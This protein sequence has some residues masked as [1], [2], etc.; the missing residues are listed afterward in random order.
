MHKELKIMTPSLAGGTELLVLA[1]IKPGFVPSLDAVTYKTRVKLLLKALH[2]G[3]KGSHEYQLFRTVSD[4]V[5]RVGVIHTVRVAVLEPENKV[6]L[7]VNFDGAYESYV[8][9]IWQKASRLLD[10]IFCN[11]VQPGNGADYPCGWEHSF[12]H[13]ATWLR[14]VTVETPFF[15]APP[16]LT[17]QDQQGL[18]MA[19]R[20]ARAGADGLATTRIGI[21]SAERMA[22][23]LVTRS[24]DPSSG[25]LANPQDNQA[26]LMGGI[27]QGLQGL[28]G[29]YRLADLYPPHTPDGLVL[30][31]AAHELLP[32]FARLQTSDAGLVDMVSSRF[33]EQVAWLRK[34]HEQLPAARQPPA[35]PNTVAVPPGAQGGIVLPYQ[36]ANVGLKP[37]EVTH[38]CIV[39]VSLGSA[40]GASALLQAL[41]PVVHT[42][43]DPVAPDQA[44]VNVAFTAEGLRTCGLTETQLDWLPDEFRQGM[45]AR[46]GVLGDVR[47]NHPRRWT[48]PLR[49]WPQALDPAW[50]APPATPTAPA[51]RVAMDAVHAVVQVRLIASGPANQAATPPT[52]TIANMLRTLLDNATL[53]AA[54]VQP[55]SVLWMARQDDAGLP[56]DHFG[57]AD[58][59]SQPG[60]NKPTAD[61]VFSNQVQLGEAL[62]GHD[63]AADHA[64]D[65]A[66]TD[67]ANPAR[68]ALLLNGSFLVVRKLRQHVGVLRKA[69]NAVVTQ[70]R[71]RVLAKMM[72]RWPTD[73]AT[74]GAPWPAVPAG[75]ANDFNYRT[76]PD[77]RQCP[78]GAHV[79]RANPRHTP[80]LTPTSTTQLASIPGGRP[81][82]FVRRS[83]PYGG[84]APRWQ[85]L[86]SGLAVDEPTTLDDDDRGLVFM[87]YNASIA[88]QFEVMQ[89]WISGGN[90]AGGLSGQTDPFLG[91]PEAG[92]RR[93]FQFEHDGITVQMQLDGSDKLGDEPRPMVALQWGA[94]LFA[95]STDGLAMLAQ[96]SAQA[97]T[98]ANPSAVPWSAA[99]G[100]AE[101]ARLR[102]IEQTSG[103]H[104]GQAAATLAWKAAL[105]DPDAVS[106]Y[107]SASIWAAIRQ[108]HSGMLRIPYGV[109][110]ANRE[111][112]DQV[113]LDTYKYYTVGGYQQRLHSSIGPIYLGLD[114]TADGEYLRQA[115]VCNAAIQQ[116][117]YSDG[118]KLGLD[119]TI[120]ALNGF[121]Q[122]AKS[123]AGAEQAPCWELNLDSKEL[124]DTVL[125]RLSEAWFGLSGSTGHFQA[126]GYRWFRG[127]LGDNGRPLYPGHFTAPSRFTFQPLP[128]AL[129]AQLAQAQGGPLTQAMT[130]YLVAVGHSITA[131]VTRAVLHSAPDTALA[132]RTLVGALMGFLPSTA[133][134]LRRILAEWTQEG[135]LLGLKARHTWVD[136]GSL[137]D[138]V[139]AADTALAEASAAAAAGLP[140][141]AT[142]AAE[143]DAAGAAKTRAI[144]QADA[145]KD[146][147]FNDAKARLRV[148]MARSMQARPV[149]ELIWRTAT[150]P[151]S[152]GLDTDT[153]V[154]VLA[155]DVLI[156]ALVSSTQQAL[157]AGTE[158]NN[159]D[160]FPIFGGKRTV[161]GQ[162]PTHACPGYES[163][164]GAMLGLLYAILQRTEA[165]RPGPAPGVLSFEG[166]MENLAPARPAA[167][168]AAAR[169]NAGSAA[170]PS[171]AARPTAPAPAPG[172]QGSLLAWGDSWIRNKHDKTG[173]FGDALAKLGYD[174]RQFAVLGLEG[175]TL[176]EMAAV[177]PDISDDTSIYAAL[178]DALLAA[179]SQVNPV[180]LP[181]ALLIGGGG[182]DIHTPD[183]HTGIA[184]LCRLLRP[185]ISGLPQLDPA[186]LTAFVDTTLAGHLRSVLGQLT[187]FTQGR[188][189]ILVHGYD[190]PIP[191]GRKYNFMPQAWLYPCIH[192]THGYAPE[193]DGRAI[194]KALIERLNTMIETVVKAFS[195]HKVHHLKLTGSLPDGTDPQHPHTDYWLN[196]LHPTV[197]GFNRLAAVADNKIRAVSTLTAAGSAT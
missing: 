196:E 97:S 102:K 149:P 59:V 115:T 51:W 100:L 60:F 167:R 27:R 145:A 7:S 29:L 136:V 41:Q 185:K 140:N 62:L 188:I 1:P 162:S 11:T 86:N 79:R 120:A 58:G 54:G 169:R 15:Y 6:L 94:Y 108:H 92:R 67:P 30:H 170:S 93:C 24:V 96:T 101:I 147:A 121:I 182:N 89:R 44:L 122:D 35:L 22:W 154:P 83:M 18:R 78:L 65:L 70:P 180:P 91:V 155:G 123:V 168:R 175:R 52:E 150:M 34:L 61:K 128:G 187:R 178:H 183:S 81:P 107:T 158:G 40:A 111:L 17:A 12:E 42:A 16:D 105:E 141:P 56:I 173:D 191:D 117:S 104:G 99:Q 193:P 43:G 9:M 181:K 19:D 10:L 21:P 77:G 84:N 50:T 25:P 135:T 160:V 148:P 166:P 46:A 146:S 129:V 172:S 143:L 124:I 179:Q 103:P 110:V 28:V 82:R 64:R 63:N 186:Q 132:A 32:E 71:D 127:G 114:D 163:A 57:F 190:Y 75:D 156:L 36:V 5:E 119:S 118:F 126:G 151:H 164:M 88:E 13:W 3:R 177:V 138:Q 4:A 55:L 109:L 95:P 171:S 174:T 74:K 106:A 161:A 194:M 85:D 144:Q 133:G 53:L 49:N 113:L 137:L 45:Q 38:A 48:L 31:R 195:Q 134:N 37:H 157:Q 23:D 142:A 176:A 39:L 131:P 130:D 73:S 98:P 2:S 125:A 184:P 197:L 139:A 33:R 189:P 153:A 8:R 90:S 152:L 116:I 26:G 80:V 76:D 159:P 68:R 14:S 69:V 20:F 112:V 47:G 192:D 66:A 87:A 165:L 72:G